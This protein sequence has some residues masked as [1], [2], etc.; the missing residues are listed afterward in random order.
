MAKIPFWPFFTPF[1]A[2]LV[3]N[4]LTAWTITNTSITSLLFVAGFILKM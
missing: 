4:F 2:M 1:F 3:N